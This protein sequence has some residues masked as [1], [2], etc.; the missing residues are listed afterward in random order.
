MWAPSTRPWEDRFGSVAG[1]GRSVARGPAWPVSRPAVSSWGPVPHVPAWP[2]RWSPWQPSA[3]SSVSF[4]DS[5]TR[6]LSDA[7]SSRAHA[8]SLFDACASDSD[9]SETPFPAPRSEISCRSGDHV[10]EDSR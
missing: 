5:E 7:R 6:F 3:P 8:R 4:G 9:W 1:A 10:A 2:A